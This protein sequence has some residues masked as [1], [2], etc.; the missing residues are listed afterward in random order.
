MKILDDLNG[1]G[2]FFSNVGSSSG[3][4][5]TCSVSWGRVQPEIPSGEE[6]GVGGGGGL[7][8]QDGY[9][10]GDYNKIARWGDCLKL[11]VPGFE[12]LPKVART[13]LDTTFGKL[14]AFII[15][16]WFF[17]TYKKAVFVNTVVAAAYVKADFSNAKF[18]GFYSADGTPN[19]IYVTG[20]KGIKR[21][22]HEIG[23]K[24]WSLFRNPGASVEYE[25]DHIDVDLYHSKSLGGAVG[26]F[27]LE[28]L[29]NK[30]RGKGT[31]P[32]DVAKKLKEKANIDTGVSCKRE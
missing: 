19:G 3:C 8:Q 32:W 27:L 9:P 16:K 11:N 21:G 14:G 20:L 29:R 26:H 2:A 28:V 25:D 18:G 31:L 24:G 1:S 17:S 7:G 23:G 12:A 10:R 5:V 4:T 15:Y 13:L 6:S 22:R 30:A